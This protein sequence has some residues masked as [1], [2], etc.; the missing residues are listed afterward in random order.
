MGINSSDQD[1]RKEPKKV[2]VDGIPDYYTD[3][4]RN[5]CNVVQND[6]CRQHDEISPHAGR[7][8][9][10]R[11]IRLLNDLFTNHQVPEYPHFV[12][13]E[14]QNNYDL[15]YDV[16]HRFDDFT[17]NS[18]V[19]RFDLIVVDGR[20]Y[21]RFVRDDKATQDLIDKR[22]AGLYGNLVP[23]E[24]TDLVAGVEVSLERHSQSVLNKLQEMLGSD[25]D[26]VLAA[27]DALAAKPNTNVPPL[28]KAKQATPSF[29]NNPYFV[30][31][32][33]EQYFVRVSKLGLLISL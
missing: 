3:H 11:I 20:S 6:Y 1:W 2:N 25:N 8:M 7:D 32:L 5:V 29:Y 30:E 24:V 17:D 27:A 23:K 22:M 18:T 33:A 15:G 13:K 4:H 12:S 26:K 14:I 31:T 9:G 19:Y 28:Q 21:L 16:F 10:G